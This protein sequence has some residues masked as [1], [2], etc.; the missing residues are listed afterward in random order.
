MESKATAKAVNQSMLVN[1]GLTIYEAIAIQKRAKSL[2]RSYEND[3][4]YGLTSRQESR[5]RTLWRDVEAIAGRNGLYVAEQG[6]PRGWPII[7][8]PEPIREDGRGPEERVC[9]Y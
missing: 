1:L 4:N 8:S 7:I 3:C 2:H 5:E 9:P 6:D